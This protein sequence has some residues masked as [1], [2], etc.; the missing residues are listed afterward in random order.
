M[1]NSLLITF[2]TKALRVSNKSFNIDKIVLVLELMIPLID[3][4]C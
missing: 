2:K 4:G 3:D 1:H